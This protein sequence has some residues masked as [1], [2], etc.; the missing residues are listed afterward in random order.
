MIDYVRR[1]SENARIGGGDLGV[2]LKT[3]TGPLAQD[4][5]DMILYRKGFG[6]QAAA[7]L[8][9]YGAYDLVKFIDEDIPFG[10]KEVRSI[11]RQLDQSRN[12][13][14]DRFIFGEREAFS[15]GGLVEGPK[16]PNTKED[17]AEAINPATGEPYTA[18][19]FLE[20]DEDV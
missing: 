15:K 8:P 20:D 5:V 7:N 1:W 17:P 2:L 4:V 16:V 18:G 9:F 11:G 12:R 14:V 19:T 6:E 13:L 10:R 3:P